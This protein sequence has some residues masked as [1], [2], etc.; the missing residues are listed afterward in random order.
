M[1]SD[2]TGA[3]VPD[4]GLTL[5]NVA[6]GE[7]RNGASGRAGEYTFAL[8]PPGTYKLTAVKSGLATV[9]VQDI[10]LP[11]NTDVRHDIT[12]S[13]AQVSQQV[14]VEAS[15]VQVD[16][17]TASLGQVVQERQILQLP[18]NGP[19]F[20]QLATLSAGVNPPA[21]Q[22]GQSV[23]QALS[24][25]R[26]SL[27]VS[28]SGAREISPE[29][30]FDGIPNKQFFY[31][32]VG[33][34]PPVDS[35]AEFKIQLGYFSPEFGLPA[36]INVATKSGTNAVHGAVWEFLRNDVLDARNFFDV[37]RHPYRQN[38]FGFAVG[39]PAIRN[40]LFWF[41]DYE[42]FRVRQGGTSFARVPTPA[43]L[44]GDFTGLPPIYDPS[45]YNAATNSRQPFLN[46]QIPPDKISTFAKD[47][48]QFIPA[49]NSAPNASLGGVNLIGTTTHALN[50]T[51][52]DIRVDVAKSQKDTFFTRFSYLNSDESGS[53]I[54]PGKGTISS[55]HSRNAVLGWTHVFNPT[56][57][58][59]F[60][61]GLDRSFLN[62]STPG[63][64]TT[65]PDWPT[66]LD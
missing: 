21:T 5:Q 24:G 29:F 8:V 32:A 33:I 35:I 54:L 60:R 2:Q 45:T 20:L 36:V 53:S 52:Y 61:A 19:D 63:G 10:A 34:E 50:D 25:G 1:V 66:K 4:V 64:A 41:G 7:V 6:T 42:G 9:V 65:S 13:V 3:A 16:T 58:N 43:M 11:V 46:N 17:E 23:K 48:N 56:L 27:T 28:V 26:P 57:V 40:K 44:Q 49:P 18:L 55:L 51:K 14:T 62:T 38:Q 39:G 12:L 22:N 47:Y 37:N 15:A 30:L 31:E 59:D